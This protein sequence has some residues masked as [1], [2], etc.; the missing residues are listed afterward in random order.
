MAFSDERNRFRVTLEDKVMDV[1]DDIKEEQNLKYNGD[2]ITFLV[3]EYK[4]LKNEQWS[5]NYVAEVVGKNL[6]ETLKEELTRVRLGTNN[7]DRNTQILIELVNGMMIN[8]NVEDI[9]T[10]DQLE[11]DGLVT[12]KN[13][14]QERIENKRQKRVEWEAARQK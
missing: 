8:D 13:V 12:A 4:R 1:I 6:H 9:M 10:T 2:A 7:T 11:S 14:V 3:N 5:L